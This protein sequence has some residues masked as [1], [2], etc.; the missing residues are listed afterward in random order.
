MNRMDFVQ[1]VVRIRV[2]EK[3]LLTGDFLEKL[4]EASGPEELR[5]SLKTTTYAEYLQDDESLFR[6]EEM[7][8]GELQKTYAGME[9]ISP[10][11][12]IVNMAALKYDC[13]NLK[14]LCKGAILKEDL[15]RLYIPVGSF[16]RQKIISNEKKHFLE[17]DGELLDLIDNMQ[18]EFSRTQDPQR[19]DIILDRMYLKELHQM[20]VSKGMPLFLEF[21]KA[22]IDFLNIRT[23]I[24]VKRQ[25]KDQAFL[26]DVLFENGNI[27]RERIAACFYD[28]EA[29]I[30]QRF[31]N[32]KIGHALIRGLES[33]RNN[34]G[35]AEFEKAMDRYLMNLLR[36]SK[37]IHFGPEPLISYLLAKEAE[38]KNLRLIIISKLYNVPP[39]RIKKRMRD[40]YV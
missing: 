9:E 37:Y 17:T 1:A 34:G 24:R 19:I 10:D 14:V 40:V 7:L 13:H 35:P 20:V 26:H 22:M 16:Y 33:E 23:L 4:I 21:V 12:D 39:V 30:M 8:S 31:R 25:G 2:L 15:S 11:P 18:K 27:D 29:T 38:I 6:Y 32:E 5:K 3:K 36:Q 28:S